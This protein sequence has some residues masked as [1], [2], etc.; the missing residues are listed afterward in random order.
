MTEGFSF[1]PATGKDAISLS[2][3]LLPQIQHAENKLL[4]TAS[5]FKAD[6]TCTSLALSGF[7]LATVD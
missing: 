1:V 6:L 4:S 3:R 2:V 5:F 7:D